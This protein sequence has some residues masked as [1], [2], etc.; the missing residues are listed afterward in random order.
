MIR[1]EK[2]RI[3][4]PAF[5]V[6]DVDL[7]IEDGDFFA[8]LGPTG[9]GKTLLLEAI[10]GL[11]PIT[12]GRILIGKRE[13]TSLPPEKRRV[14]IVYQDHALFPHLT[15]RQ[16]IAFGLR[17]CEFDKRT[18]AHN[19]KWILDELNRHTQIWPALENGV[20]VKTYTL[21]F[22]RRK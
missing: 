10:G 7:S 6:D 12:S 1:L 3:N 11:V 18:A 8:L 2:V 19:L 9:A 20:L 15:V 16:N 5:S 21:E 22:T 4:L 13:I 17:Y 14:G